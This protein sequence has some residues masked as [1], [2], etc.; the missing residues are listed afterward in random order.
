MKELLSRSVQSRYPAGCP[1][2]MEEIRVQF[3]GIVNVL[4]GIRSVT[5]K[6]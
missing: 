5:V 2:G 6:V 3:V 4:T 1:Q